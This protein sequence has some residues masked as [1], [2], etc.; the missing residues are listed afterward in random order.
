MLRTTIAPDVMDDTVPK[1]DNENDKDV[2][3]YGLVV[4]VAWAPSLAQTDKDDKMVKYSLV[5]AL[6]FEWSSFLGH[7]RYTGPPDLLYRLRGEL[8]WVHIIEYRL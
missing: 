2:Q 7:R 1:A 4:T 3:F 8:N 5:I 6:E